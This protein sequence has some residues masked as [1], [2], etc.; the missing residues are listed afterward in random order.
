MPFHK[1]VFKRV[2]RPVGTAK[3]VGKK[4]YAETPFGKV[5]K[6]QDKKGK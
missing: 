1:K 4:L 3:H 2:T 6:A 5:K